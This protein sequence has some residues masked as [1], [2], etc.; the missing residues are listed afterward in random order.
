VDKSNRLSEKEVRERLAL[1]TDAKIIDEL[2]TF[3]QMML[4]ETVARVHLIDTKAASMAAYG[5]AIVTLLVSTSAAWSR[6]GGKW[7]LAIASIAGSLAFLAAVCAVKVMALRD[8][9][10]LSEEEWLQTSCLSD[11]DKLKRYRSLT[12]WAAMN[13]YKT[14]HVSKVRLLEKAQ[15][16]LALAVFLLLVTFLQITWLHALL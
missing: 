6:V 14:A 13:S 16:L 4:K 5:G 7:T 3:G 12:I 2:Y 8:F 15:T 9:D 11:T 1:C 10:W